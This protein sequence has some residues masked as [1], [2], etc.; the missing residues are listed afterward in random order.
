MPPV[1]AQ[2][3]R[4][5]QQGGQ[6]ERLVGRR[7]R[8]HDGRDSLS[9]SPRRACL[10]DRHCPPKRPRRPAAFLGGSVGEQRRVEF[11]AGAGDQPGAGHAVDGNGRQ[12]PSW[13]A[14]SSRVLPSTVISTCV[15]AGSASSSAGPVSVSSRVTSAAAASSRSGSS[16]AVTNASGSAPSPAMPPREGESGS[17]NGSRRT[18]TW[19]DRASISLASAGMAPAS[20]SARVRD[21]PTVPVVDRMLGESLTATTA[22]NPTPKR[23]TVLPLDTSPRLLDAR[24]VDR[25]ST[26]AASSGAPVFHATRTP[27]RSVSR[28]RPGTPPRTAA[29]AAFCASSTTTRSRYPPSA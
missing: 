16:T 26:P 27:S 22:A 7:R 14:V 29:S 21:Q 6:A 2:R 17:A 23:P 5:E 25:A 1:R 12:S 4:R 24:S 19:P 15:R 18:G 11:A 13:T 8:V 3:E 9:Q 10:G 20:S 28:S